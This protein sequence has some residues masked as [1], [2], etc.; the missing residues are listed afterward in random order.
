[1]AGSSQVKPGHDGW[2]RASNIVTI[3]ATAV[4]FDDSKR[5]EL[6][7]GSAIGVPYACMG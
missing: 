5:V 7:D 4:R 1:V 3:S 2:R 6:S